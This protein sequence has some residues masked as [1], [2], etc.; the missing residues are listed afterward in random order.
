MTTYL[1]NFQLERTCV[2]KDCNDNAVR[3]LILHD[4]ED[5][6]M[7]VCCFCIAHAMHHESMFK[8][9]KSN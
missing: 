9:G 5:N 4:T 1:G 6:D 7:T 8:E 3:I 2:A